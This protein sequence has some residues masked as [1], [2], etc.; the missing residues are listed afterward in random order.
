[1]KRINHL[2]GTIEGCATRHGTLV[3]PVMTDITGFEEI[4]PYKGG[5]CG[6]D[7]APGHPARGRAGQGARDGAQVRR[8]ALRRGLQGRLLPRLPARYRHQRGL[9]RRAEPADQR[10]LA[11]D[12][13]DH[14]HLRRLPAVPV[15]PARV[16]RRRLGARPRGGA[17]ALDRL[18]QLDAAGAEADRGQ[19]RADHPGAALGHLEDGAGRQRAASCGRRSTSPASATRAR[20]STCGSTARAN[21]ATTAPISAS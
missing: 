21:T 6:N 19:G 20:P 15:P 10:R 5:W 7:M 4:T 2:P 11:A 17:G 18:R 16:P 14:H 13:P 3:G 8:P 9:P 12:Q 1:M